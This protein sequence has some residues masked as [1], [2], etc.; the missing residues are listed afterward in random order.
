MVIKT[1]L[2][3]TFY[4][5]LKQSLD[6][7]GRTIYGQ[8]GTMAA[9]VSLMC[10]VGMSD[11]GPGPNTQTKPYGILIHSQTHIHSPWS[12][13]FAVFHSEL[14]DTS[15]P[16]WKTATRKASRPYED[17]RAGCE[18]VVLA[19]CVWA[20]MH[21][22][23]LPACSYASLSRLCQAVRTPI[24]LWTL[25]PGF[26]PGYG[27]IERRHPPYTHH[28]VRST[29]FISICRQKQQLGMYKYRLTKGITSTGFPPPLVV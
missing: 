23:F 25:P 12:L 1:Q 27:V 28:V 9:A 3:P 19:R 13:T 20:W 11:V 8:W 14:V 26:T 7:A 16:S 15:I 21:L 18:L 10:C 6:D 5:L 4:K 24:N 17:G 22:W 2:C 29:T